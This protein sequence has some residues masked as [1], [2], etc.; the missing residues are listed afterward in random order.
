MALVASEADAGWPT[1]GNR[2]RSGPSHPGEGAGAEDQGAHEK[3]SAAENKAG[4]QKQK[5]RSSHAG[6]LPMDVAAVQNGKRERYGKE[7]INHQFSPPRSQ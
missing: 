2:L 5:A 4:S 7:G 3:E 6:H 1:Q